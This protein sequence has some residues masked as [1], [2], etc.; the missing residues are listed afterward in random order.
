M[1]PTEPGVGATNDD[2]AI[3]E[4]HAA[5]KRRRRRIMAITALVC[6]AIGAVVLLIT[7]TADENMDGTAGGRYEVKTIAAGIAFV[8]A[9]LGAA[10]KAITGD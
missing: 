5:A 7:F 9:G 3:A 10:G 4:F 8:V 2:A 6:I 1:E